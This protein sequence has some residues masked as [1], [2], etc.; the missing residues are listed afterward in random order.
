ML[1]DH[2]PILE[3]RTMLPNRFLNW[4]KCLMN[5]LQTQRASTRTRRRRWMPVA[6]VEQLE[7]RQLLSAVPIAAVTSPSVSDPGAVTVTAPTPRSN[8][9]QGPMAFIVNATG[10]VTIGPPGTGPGTGVF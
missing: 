6:G 8:I 4:S 3:T 7:S 5:G 2:P 10:T 1:Q 9:Q